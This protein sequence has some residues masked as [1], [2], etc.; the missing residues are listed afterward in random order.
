MTRRCA[1]IAALL[2]AA[3]ALACGRGEEPVGPPPPEV[4]VAAARIGS[5]PDRREYVGNVRAMN[6][7]D[8]RA[9]VRGYLKER[10]F[11]EGHFVEQGQL[12]S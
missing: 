3:H 11:E 2:L 1:G 8:L 9:R 10:R 6:A 4:V 12:L 7:V 5:V